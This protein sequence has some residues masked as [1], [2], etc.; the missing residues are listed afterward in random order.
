MF[1]LYILW[2]ILIF[3]PVFWEYVWS[4]QK[5]SMKQSNLNVYGIFQASQNASRVIEMV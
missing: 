2:H 5:Q 3:Y 4:P 1:H